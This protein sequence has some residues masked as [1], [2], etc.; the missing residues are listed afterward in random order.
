MWPYVPPVISPL[1]AEGAAG[2]AHGLNCARVRHDGF[3][4]RL[5]VASRF[6]WRGIVPTR[7]RWFDER[8]DSIRNFLE[9]GAERTSDG[10]LLL[11]HAGGSAI[12]LGHVYRGANLRLSREQSPANL[13]REFMSG[14][15]RKEAFGLIFLRVP[16]SPSFLGEFSPPPSNVCFPLLLEDLLSAL[17]KSWCLLWRRAFSRRAFDSSASIFLSEGRFPKITEIVLRGR[18]RCGALPLPSFR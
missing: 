16:F 14:A 13:G 18:A 15:G 5:R 8:L 6:P 2:R 4:P 11:C 12:L 10:V 1:H 3:P 17:R 7:Q 9:M